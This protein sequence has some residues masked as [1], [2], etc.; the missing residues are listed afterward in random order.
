MRIMKIGMRGKVH[1]T[2]IA[3]DQSW[4]RSTSTVAGVTVEASTSW[5]R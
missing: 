2:A 1:T 4:V 3:A 5:G